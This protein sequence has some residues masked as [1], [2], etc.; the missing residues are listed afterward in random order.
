MSATWEVFKVSQKWNTWLPAI[1]VN[2]QVRQV[3]TLS[4]LSWSI[5]SQKK[6]MGIKQ[7][8]ILTFLCCRR[9][10]FVAV[11]ESL[12]TS[13]QVVRCTF[14][15][16]SQNVPCYLVKTL[17]NHLSWYHFTGTSNQKVKSSCEHVLLC[18]VKYCIPKLAAKTHG[19]V[20]IYHWLSVNGHA[21]L[22]LH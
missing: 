13:V 6:H 12:S 4:Q 16:R 2:L 9:Q 8:N 5:S 19:G 20:T 21:M 10:L 18:S 22:L 15:G 11:H 7:W 14:I 1:I 17:F 3:F